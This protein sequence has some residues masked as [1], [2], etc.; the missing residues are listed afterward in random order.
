MAS[1]L[2]IYY[3]HHFLNHDTG[4][5]HPE[6]P[7]R[8]KACVSAL[9][10]C[11]FSDQL[12]WKS[13]RVATEEELSWIH[14]MQHIEHIK[15]VCESGGGYLDSDTPVC[16]ES[17]DIALKSAGA[18]L[19]G[20]E[21]VINNN[22]VFILSRPP[23]H[24]AEENRAMG[25][26]LFSNAALAAVAALKQKGINRV[27]IFDW[28]VHHG[29]GTQNIIQNNPNI[30]YVSTHQFPFFPGT[31]S[32]LETGE[33]N[34]VLN[35]PLYAGVGSTDYKNKFNEAVIP[36]IQKSDPDI[37]IISAGFDAHRRDPLA[38]IN[39]ETKD[40]VYMIK[41]LQ[42]IKPNLLVGLEGGYDLKALGE[43]CEAVA[44]A[45]IGCS[46]KI[47]KKGA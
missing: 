36:F 22:S 24:H 28:D 44:S 13:P 29:N 25:F 35:I 38:S 3:S 39:L 27:C 23:G 41:I 32:Q 14:T 46:S 15:Q 5:G 10:N 43:C 33:H 42:K 8:L 45:L 30:F 4:V 18:W 37:L 7:D 12:V 9:K 19:D 16:S 6:Q 26:C 11:Y 20:I 31:G 2:P 17:Y 34:N 1:F 40:F 47:V 21:E